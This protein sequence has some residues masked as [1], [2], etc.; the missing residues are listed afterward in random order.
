MYI[1]WA[2]QSF[3]NY[4]KQITMKLHLVTKLPLLKLQSPNSLLN[5][6]AA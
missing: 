2:Q 4:K 6:I 1:V 5:N 3:N